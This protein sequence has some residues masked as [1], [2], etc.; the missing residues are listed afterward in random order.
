MQDLD[1][2]NLEP[3]FGDAAVRGH[4]ALQSK[5]LE[6]VI[7]YESEA[8][9]CDEWKRNVSARLEQTLEQTLSRP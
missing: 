9:R 4:L 6:T 5:A 8:S 1:R 7:L 2:R 3:V